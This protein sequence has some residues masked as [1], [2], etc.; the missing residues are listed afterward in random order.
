MCVLCQREWEARWKD[1]PTR[2]LTAFAKYHVITLVMRLYEHIAAQWYDVIT[3]DKLTMDPCARAKMIA[4]KS[5]SSKSDSNQ[6]EIAKE[7]FHTTFWGHL[8]AFLADYSVHQVILCYGYYVYVRERRKRKSSS[9]NK[10]DDGGVSNNDSEEG[11]DGAILTS[12][13][14]KS[15]QLML[16]RG[17]GLMCSSVGGAVGSVLWPGT[18]TLLFSSMGEGAA[19]VVMDDG[20][21]A[22]K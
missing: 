15:T 17:I 12:M 14:K 8:I 22:L 16:N 18:G 9:G 11:L 2:V 7:M 6:T 5:S 1:F 21:Q 20:M 10:R 19:S 3:V 13:L 4:A